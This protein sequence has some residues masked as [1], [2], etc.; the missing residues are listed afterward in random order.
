MSVHSKAL[1]DE[2]LWFRLRGRERIAYYAGDF[3]ERRIKQI[4]EDKYDI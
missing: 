3:P 4:S 2:K 1:P